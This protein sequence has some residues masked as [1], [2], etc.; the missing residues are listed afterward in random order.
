MVI[1]G[2]AV[3]FGVSQATLSTSVEVAKTRLAH[4]E[5]KTSA[6]ETEIADLRRTEAAHMAEAT[7]LFKEQL[8][9]MQDFVKLL[10]DQNAL[11]I[12]T[13]P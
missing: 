12:K 13:H 2:A 1:F 5:A 8:R 6:I 3:G 10:K 7:S 9:V 4:V 11:L